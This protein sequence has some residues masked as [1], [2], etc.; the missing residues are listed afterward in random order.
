M[1]ITKCL[2]LFLFLYGK[3]T[4]KTTDKSVVP[5]PGFVACAGSGGVNGVSDPGSTAS[6]ETAC[7]D[8]EGL[9]YGA[10][11]GADE[12]ADELKLFKD[13]PDGNKVEIKSTECYED[14]YLGNLTYA[15]K[16][17]VKC[18]IVKFED[19]DVWK[20]GDEQVDE[21]KSVTYDSIL[22][23]V[24]VRDAS[25]SV[26][27]GK[28]SETGEWKHVVT[29]PRTKMA[30]VDKRAELPP[31]SHYAASTDTSES[32]KVSGED[33][34]GS[35]V[36]SGEGGTDSKQPESSYQPDQDS[37]TVVTSPQQTSTS[38][39]SSSKHG[40]GSSTNVSESSQPESGST[41]T[42][43]TGQVLISSIY[44]TGAASSYVWDVDSHGSRGSSNDPNEA[45]GSSKS[46]GEPSESSSAPIKNNQQSS[47][48]PADSSST[49]TK[50]TPDG[51]GSASTDQSDS[52]PPSVPSGRSASGQGARTGQSSTS[53]LT[54]PAG[55]TSTQAPKTG[56]QQ[57][58]SGQGGG[59]GADGSVASPPPADGGSGT[60]TSYG[61]GSGTN[62]DGTGTGAGDGSS[63]TPPPSSGGDGASESSSSDLDIKFFA[64]DP[65]DDNKTVELD[66][67]KYDKKETNPTRIDH[68]LKTEVKCTLI[69]INNKEL[70]KQED[71]CNENLKSVSYRNAI[72]LVLNV[73]DAYLRY[74]KNSKGEWKRRAHIL[75]K[76]KVA[77]S[78]VLMEVV[79]RHF[80]LKL[81]PPI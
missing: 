3:N 56:S 31:K 41:H 46:S 25:N 67:K 62:D 39:K 18:T 59:A 42:S 74:G 28:E 10:A 8:H 16:P 30:M 66:S 78:E 49:Q 72:T 45:D 33:E 55:Q 71:N 4:V 23:E 1:L 69:K 17:G 68:E 13:D 19:K 44:P 73:G 21:T 58:S 29:I 57:V 12:P 27:F 43:G 70:W 2:L 32:H 7:S 14:Q 54:V 64:K 20:K 34:E 37:T 11:N 77:Q 38:D 60:Q 79:N 80:L 48:T 81:V 36:A 22:G 40:D 26:H 15:F 50:K 53:T 47:S 75:D 6:G 35:T 24:V 52:T 9:T 5:S 51:S 76:I 65:N 63:A 61:E